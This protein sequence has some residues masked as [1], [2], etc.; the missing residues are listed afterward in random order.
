MLGY[1]PTPFN[2][3]TG[4]SHTCCRNDGCFRRCSA[5]C[6]AAPL[7]RQQCNCRR[8][9]LTAKWH[10]GLQRPAAED[11]LCRRCHRRY[12][13]HRGCCRQATWWSALV[14]QAAADAAPA[15]TIVS[16]PC[17]NTPQY[18]MVWHTRIAIPSLSLLPRI[19]GAKWSTCSALVAHGLHS[20]LQIP[21]L[22][23][24][25][26]AAPSSAAALLLGRL[27][28]FVTMSLSSTTGA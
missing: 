24:A 9:G 6:P 26:A 3:V 27:A 4:L 10:G 22:P 19:A 17:C 21:T 8:H 13:C 1:T 23:G 28:A 5:P 20:H 18:H 16:S 25:S 2:N 14:G 12:C 7:L 11:T 15:G